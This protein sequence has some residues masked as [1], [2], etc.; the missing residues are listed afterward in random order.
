ML[1]ISERFAL[2]CFCISFSLTFRI[3]LF[4]FICSLFCWSIN[5]QQFLEPDEVVIMIS[6]VKKLQKLTNKKVQLILTNKPKLIY[7]DPSKLVVK[8]NIM[9]SDNPKEMSVHVANPSNFKIVTVSVLIFYFFFGSFRHLFPKF[10]IL[11]GISTY[12]EY[13]YIF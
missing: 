11:F 1:Y 12:L 4:D 2:W 10:D 6:M 3:C 5:R 7:V 9:W 13:I 8:G